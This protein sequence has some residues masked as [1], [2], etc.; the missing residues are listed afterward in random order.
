M[1]IWFRLVWGLSLAWS[2]T[3]CARL[4]LGDVPHQTIPSLTLSPIQ[5]SDA[6]VVANNSSDR[7]GIPV[8]FRETSTLL[9]ARP[10]ADF[11][12]SSTLRLSKNGDG[13]IS[14]HSDGGSVSLLRGLDPAL[15][16]PAVRPFLF[17]SCDVPTSP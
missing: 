10:A 11:F 3:A 17:P 8:S 12:G 7:S 4:P 5:G 6:G 9:T 15:V 16:N 13:S 2:F 14:V 1:G